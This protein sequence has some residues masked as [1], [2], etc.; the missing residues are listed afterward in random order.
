M[1]P[2]CSV[3]ADA[4]QTPHRGAGQVGDVLTGQRH[5]A[6]GDHHQHAGVVLGQPRLHAPPAPDGWPRASVAA[7][8]G[9]IR[10]RTGNGFEDAR[11]RRTSAGACGAASAGDQSTSKSSPRRWDR[12]PRRAQLLG[13][14]RRAAIEPTDSTGKPSPSASSIDTELAPTG[15]IRARTDDAPAACSDTCC[16][17]NGSAS[18]MS[19]PA[20]SATACRAASSRPGCTPNSL[21]LHVLRH[22]DLGEDLVAAPP[23]RGQA[24]E[25]RAVLVAA[26]G[27]RSRSRRS[28]STATA[29]GGRP[30]RQIG[31]RRRPASAVDDGLGVQQPSR[32]PRRRAGRTPTPHAARLARAVPGADRPPRGRAPRTGPRISGA[33]SVSSSIV[34]Q[35]TSSP[36]RMTNS[37]NPA[38][39]NSTIP[40]TA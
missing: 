23:H 29:P 31:A 27:Q 5:R 30:R 18:S 16:H 11:R 17:E 38:P 21:R 22:G 39:G 40:P 33:C 36:A 20:A 6:A 32:S 25:R 28:T 7:T 15:A 35:P 3:C 14:D 24:P 2:G 26:R 1:R 8:I 4:H 37:T 13:A 9:G 34:G 12:G 19:A 10:L